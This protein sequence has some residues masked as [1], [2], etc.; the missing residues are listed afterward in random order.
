VIH[1]HVLA[2]PTFRICRCNHHC[3]RRIV[4]SGG[5]PASRWH[6][7]AP[8]I[9]GIV[10]L[11]MFRYYG[12]MAL[13]YTDVL[14]S[15]FGGRRFTAKEFARRSGNLRGAKLLSELKHRGV[16]ERIDR[17]TYRCLG[18]SERPDLRSG[19]WARVREIVLAGPAPKAW[20]GA[21]AVEL[22]T[23]GRYRWAPSLYSR[24]FELAVPR[25]RMGM[26]TRYLANRG[27]STTSGKRIG[28]H[29]R[30]VPTEKLAVA[31]VEG[32]PVVRREEVERLIRE[33][34]GLYGNARELLLD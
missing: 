21:T 10:V 33:H 8:R 7:R 31:S 2:I 24:I 6:P 20:A 12:S 3:N 4:P 25:G 16:V 13:T 1:E 18:P 11:Y 5:C 19:E 17:G 30:L 32:E 15:L 9:D 29:V 28:A 26:W 34:P 14:N 27:V 22:W 23:G